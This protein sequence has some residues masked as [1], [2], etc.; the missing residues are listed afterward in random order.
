M[1]RWLQWTS[2]SDFS[3][4]PVF[5]KTGSVAAFRFQGTVMVGISFSH[6][7]LSGNCDVCCC[8]W[9]FCHFEIIET[10]VLSFKDSQVQQASS[11]S[12]WMHKTDAK[13]LL[14]FLLLT[15]S[16]LAFCPSFLP[17]LL[18]CLLEATQ[19]HLKWDISCWDREYS[20]QCHCLLL[21]APAFSCLLPR[22]TS[23]LLWAWLAAVH[24]IRRRCL[25][26]HAQNRLFD[27]APHPC[28]TPQH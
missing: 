20:W 14:L 5:N 8:S 6:L 3:G 4:L 18:I 27:V 23:V 25:A 1:L 7:R 22:Q 11:L 26:A 17:H 2:R 13:P 9:D 12:I 16:L 24:L 10:S 28:Q 21:M 19:K 15:T